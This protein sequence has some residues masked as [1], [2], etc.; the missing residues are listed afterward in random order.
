MADVEKVPI[1]ARHSMFNNMT[2][3][4]VDFSM[5]PQS[6][7]TFDQKIKLTSK[8]SIVLTIFN[9][10]RSFVAIGILTLPYATS[11]VGPALAT[12]S[13]LLIALL[14][15]LATDCI[16]EVADDVKF[17]GANYET[18]GRLLWGRV[19]QQV[20][21][22]TLYFCSFACFIGGIL[23]TS[24]FLDFA[25][26]SHKVDALC[27]SKVKYLLAAF[28]LSI[29][30]STIQS[31]KPFGYISIASTFVIIIAVASITVYNV[32]FVLE[33]RVD[34]GI[35]LTEFKIKNFFRFL[36]IGLYTIEGINLILPIRASFKDN[37]RYPKVLYATFV[38][39][40]WCYLI[41][42]VM[43]YIVT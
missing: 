27:H 37:A 21:I 12:F 29:L 24:D 23:F 19:G 42:A 11:L 40:V 3:V 30:I 38:F 14:V 22:V 26:C 43:S 41:L 32:G 9:V 6:E 36:G 4:E 25:F 17:K 18:L 20:V 33:T 8:K 34:L 31:L 39:V 5:D 13:M 10:F 7:V 15:Y 35:R 2:N 16:I 28:G 1:A